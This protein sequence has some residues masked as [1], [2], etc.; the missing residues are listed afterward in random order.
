MYK[1]V[2]MENY[3]NFDGRARRKEYWMFVLINAIIG[4]GLLFILGLVS[5]KLALVSSVYN[6]AVLVPS[7][8]VGV[9]RMHDVGKSGWYIIFPIYNLVLACTE[10]ENGP[11]QY[12][13]DPKNESGE[14]N[15][16]GKE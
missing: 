13:S 9:R 11:N 6:L 14:I 2:V 7:I 10:G 3:A 4:Y 8:A 16:I 15:E 5:P 12:G 1:K